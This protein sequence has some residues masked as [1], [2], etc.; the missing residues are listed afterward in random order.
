MT[1]VINQISKS[2]F[3][4]KIFLYLLPLYNKLQGFSYQIFLVIG[5]GI[6]YLS[7]KYLS[8]TNH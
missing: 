6:G 1:I 7:F 3:N 5:V 8:I 2:H 4:T